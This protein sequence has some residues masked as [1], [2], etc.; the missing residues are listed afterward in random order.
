MQPP[1]LPQTPLMG[2]ELGITERTPFFFHI[3][4]M[5][6]VDERV[7]AICLKKIHHKELPKSNNIL[8]NYFEL[9]VMSP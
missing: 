5:I 7:V 4:F 8:L 6:P 9:H 3:S 1:S 2:R